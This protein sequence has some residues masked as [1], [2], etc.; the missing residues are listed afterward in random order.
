MLDPCGVREDR[1]PSSLTALWMVEGYGLAMVENSCCTG[2]VDCG[3]MSPLGCSAQK[4]MGLR[5]SCRIE[6][7]SGLGGVPPTCVRNISRAN[8]QPTR[9]RASV[10]GMLAAACSIWRSKTGDAVPLLR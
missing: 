6:M 9:S 4:S 5:G 3:L 1:D 8:A 10:G 2:A 7:V